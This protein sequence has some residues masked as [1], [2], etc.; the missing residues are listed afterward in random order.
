LGIRTN[1]A[2]YT[3]RSIASALSATLELGPPDLA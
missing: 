3:S 2:A 1:S